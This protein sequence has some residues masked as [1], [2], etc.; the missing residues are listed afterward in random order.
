[1]ALYINIGLAQYFCGLAGVT[2]VSRMMYAFARD[3]G[4]PGSLWLRQV[5]P[6]LRTPAAAVWTSAL[7]ALSF[8]LWVPYSA[9][10][11]CSTVLLYISYVLPIFAG[12]L[13]HGRTWTKMGP[14]QMGRAYRPLAMISVLGCAGLIV[15]GVQPPNEIAVKILGGTAVLMLLAWFGS[16]RKRFQGP[17]RMT[18]L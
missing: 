9:I 2:S 6:A 10:A 16:E 17:P 1:V 8:M 3:G 12:L 18:G 5:S 4:L 15:I 7:L 13:A 14:W 11:A